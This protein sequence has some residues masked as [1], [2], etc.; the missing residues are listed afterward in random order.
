[1]YRDILRRLN[2]LFYLIL[3]LI[4]IAIQSTIFSYFPLNLLQPDFLL[5]LVV[6][7]GFQRSILEG[8]FLT[9]SAALFFELHSSNGK[10]FYL[11]I[12][13]YVFLI[14]K[15]LSKTL[16]TP[17]SV[18]SMGIVAALALFKK[19]GIAVLVT[20]YGRG[21]NGLFYYVLHTVPYILVQALLTPVCFNWFRSIDLRTYKDE[22]AEDEYDLSR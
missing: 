15:L 11:A 12:Y 9:A 19:I 1:M 5:I 7:F 14:S 20:I 2:F 16:V 3:A 18:A 8:S 17:D 4:A 21:V 22:H 13:L 6:Y 10:F